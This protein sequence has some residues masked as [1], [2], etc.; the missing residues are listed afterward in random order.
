MRPT[1]FAKLMLPEALNFLDWKQK[2]VE[3][4]MF[5][6]FTRWIVF[7]SF[8]Q[9]MPRNK[10]ESDVPFSA[11]IVLRKEVHIFNLS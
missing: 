8:L 10:I 1:E 7:T 9:D 2:T 11:P 5:I 3:S 6:Y 4:N